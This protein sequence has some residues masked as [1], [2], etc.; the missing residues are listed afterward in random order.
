MRALYGVGLLQ[1]LPAQTSVTYSFQI[2]QSASSAADRSAAAERRPSLLAGTALKFDLILSYH[3][4]FI[5]L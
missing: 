4:C 5:N 1:S 2:R 3:P